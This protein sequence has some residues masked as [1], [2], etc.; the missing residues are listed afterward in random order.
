M[1][2]LIC[3]YKQKRDTDYNQKQEKASF[4]FQQFQTGL[5]SGNPL[6]IDTKLLRNTQCLQRHLA[7]LH[8]HQG[9]IH[10]ALR[11]PFNFQTSAV[12]VTDNDIV[13]CHQQ[14]YTMPTQYLKQCGD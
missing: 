10:F 12:M 5:C 9:V 14:A 7:I 13:G 3:K 1:Y 8:L 6:R 4:L 11:K 2:F